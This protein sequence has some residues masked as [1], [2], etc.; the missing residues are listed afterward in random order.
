M[1]PQPVKE[2]IATTAVSLSE[3]SYVLWV[4][5][6]S[7]GTGESMLAEELVNSTLI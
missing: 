2:D 7:W 1:I 5:S 4:F 3:G 6:W